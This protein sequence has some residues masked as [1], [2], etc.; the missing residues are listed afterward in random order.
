MIE[1]KYGEHVPKGDLP[2]ILRRFFLETLPKF[3]YTVRNEQVK[4]AEQM[5]HTL[6]VRG[7]LLAE[8]GVGIGKTFAYLI[9]AVLIKRGRTND[10]WNHGF[11]PEMSYLS[12][13]DMPIVISTS[14]IALQKA[15]VE[16]YVPK[17]SDI[18]VAEG[19][20]DTPLTV[21]LR[22]GKEHY[23]CEQKLRTHIGNKPDAATNKI[24]E[25]LAEP[26]ASIDLDEVDGL[27]A[28]I[29]R[30]ICV[31][32]NCHG[33]CPRS[34]ECRYIDFLS[35]AM[36]PKIDIQVCNHQ[37]LIAD[38]CRRA[39]GIRPL[40]PNYQAV[41]IDEAHK[42]S[43][44]AEQI[45]GY[46]FTNIQV[47]ELKAVITDIHFKS[48]AK[49]ADI[50]RTAKELSRHS[51]KLFQLL[52][53]VPEYSDESDRVGVFVN[54]EIIDNIRVIRNVAQRLRTDINDA[55]VFAVHDE[56]KRNTLRQLDK[57]IKI[58]EALLDRDNLIY[59]TARTPEKTSLFAQ[60]HDL[61]KRLCN[62]FWNRNL[63]VILT[64]GTL[65]AS[66][67]FTRVKD[68]LG[69]KNHARH[70]GISVPSPFDY[71]RNA[72]LYIS[73]TT[74]YPKNDSTDYLNS[75]TNE[76]G[77]LLH[78]SHGHAAVLFTSYRVMDI[79]WEKMQN[80]QFPMFRLDKGGVNAIEQFKQS[81]NGVLFASGSM[82]E[83]IDIPGDALSMLII[84]KLP[85]AVPDP[86]SD[87]ERTRY[88]D[89][90]DYKNSVIVPDML[91]KLKQG[92]GRLIR[93][94]SD[95][96][97]V[98]LLDSRAGRFGLYRDAVLNAMPPCEV[99]SSIGA[100]RKFINTK[101]SAE[102]FN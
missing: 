68:K 65:S 32:E 77:K 69:M 26:S 81:G 101:K 12:V 46:E 25:S 96:G 72:M 48:K 80:T 61:D 50:S 24:L 13:A 99:T 18:L 79:V 29:K 16:D 67:D 53:E 3:G 44:A 58:A 22:K 56:L 84:V 85:F 19:Y 42:L 87:F 93:K 100:V 54:R 43:Q 21:T 83:G 70:A 20:I 31:P 89:F 51:D 7:T 4:L 30:C 14:S 71:N 11:Y 34:T 90:D 76:V 41:I 6:G 62:D 8:A 37:Y 23:I 98:A 66:G 52:N 95:T 5:L 15:I 82:W 57:T 47:P 102:Y 73:D 74:P 2:E 38:T 9:A 35:T 63:P 10:F 1:R 49:S 78:A 86:V 28:F 60:P 39:D 94:E 36:N 45:Y 64:S 91:L 40:I 97:V 88:K 92:F 27:N 33:G 55:D 17:L 59:W 75:I